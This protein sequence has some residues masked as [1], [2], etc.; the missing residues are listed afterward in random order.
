MKRS[1]VKNSF[2]LPVLLTGLSMILAARVTAQTF[3][4]L[5]SF[6]ATFGPFPYTN[7]DGANPQAELI[8]SNNAL[9]GT[10]EKGGS[11][12]YGTV[13]KVN[14]NGTAFTTLHHFSAQY[15]NST[16]RNDTNS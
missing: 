12:G 16:V 5:H 9:Y 15:Y 8:L 2:L 14:I 13:F 1:I 4:T 10:T 11:S 6:T 7:L 3:T